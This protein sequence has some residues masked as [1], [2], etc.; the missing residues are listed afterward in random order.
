MSSGS[1]RNRSPW[2][3]S[4]EQLDPGGV[5]EMGSRIHHINDLGTFL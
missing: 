2:S 1:Q 4:S 5:R 3:S